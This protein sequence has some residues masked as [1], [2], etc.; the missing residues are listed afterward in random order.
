MWDKT[1]SIKL[2]LFITRFFAV[3][4]VAIAIFAYPF[5][6]WYVFDFFNDESQFTVNLLTFGAYFSIPPAGI[7][8]YCLNK[9]LMNIKVQKTFEKEN[10]KM[11][12]IISWCCFYV[13]LEGII[14]SIVYAP[15]FSFA[16][17][18]V[19]FSAFFVGLLVRVVKNVLDSAIEIKE[20]NELT[21]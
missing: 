7:T 14:C 10:V 3:V 11:L 5:F 17:L 18:V 13:V 12:R 19:T 21:I 2:S 8:L 16:F 6:K 9:L 20:E 1:K 15:N 4:L